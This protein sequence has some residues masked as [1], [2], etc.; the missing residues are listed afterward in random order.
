MVILGEL[1]WTT[2]LGYLT[3]KETR[4]RKPKLK[5]DVSSIKNNA[6]NKKMIGTIVTG[7]DSGFGSGWSLWTGWSAGDTDGDSRRASLWL[8]LLIGSD[9]FPIWFRNQFY[10]VAN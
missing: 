1:K 8:R 10:L 5:L 9:E 3:E 7:S 6:M 2:M 4:K